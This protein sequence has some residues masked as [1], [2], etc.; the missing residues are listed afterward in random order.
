MTA[1]IQE[2][3]ATLHQTLQGYIEAAYHIAD[4]GIVAQRRALLASVGG[5]FQ[6][7]C[8]ESTPR[9]ETG[10]AYGDMTDI[11]TLASRFC[12]IRHTAIRRS[13]SAPF[14]AIA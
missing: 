7:P 5:I 8:L 12:S 4:P 3:I 6:T 11:P 1:T 13:R 9:H 10:D 14:C 2:T